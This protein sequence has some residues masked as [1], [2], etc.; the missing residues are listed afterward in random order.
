VTYVIICANSQG[1]LITQVA[2]KVE[3]GWELQGGVSV[4]PIDDASYPRGTRVY[5]QAMVFTLAQ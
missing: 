4:C 5:S 3:E 2:A 1:D